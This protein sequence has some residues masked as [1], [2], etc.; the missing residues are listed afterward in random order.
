MASEQLECASAAMLSYAAMAAAEVHAQ[1]RAIS[2]ELLSMLP[3]LQ[4]RFDDQLQC[5]R[6]NGQFFKT[7]LCELQI[8]SSD[9]DDEMDEVEEDRHSESCED[10]SQRAAAADT[11][12][13]DLLRLQATLFQLRREWSDDG[14]EERE[15]CFGPMLQSLHDYASR[16]PEEGGRQLR[17]LVPGAGLGRLVYEAS[18][19]GWVARLPPAFSEMHVHTLK[20]MP[21]TGVLANRQ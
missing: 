4:L 17:V 20:G 6:R 19:D 7:M 3:E 1:R 14:A 8:L 16:M 2:T 18:A 9:A 5:V 12:P 10:F 15:A 21:H 13:A 11:A